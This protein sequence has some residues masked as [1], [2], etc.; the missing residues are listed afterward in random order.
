MRERELQLRRWARLLAP[1]L[2][3]LVGGLLALEEGHARG[4]SSAATSISI[5]IRPNPSNHG[6]P[7][8]IAGRLS[9]GGVA[10]QPVSIFNRPSGAA[11]FSQVARTATKSSGAYT[12]VVKGRAAATNGTWYVT[13]AGL[14][15]ATVNERVFSHVTL[16]S[17]TAGPAVAEKVT[18]SGR[19]SPAEPGG[20][21]QLQS[22]AGSRWMTIARPRLDRRSR[23]S[24]VKIFA[25]TGI[26]RLRALAPVSGGHGRWISPTIAIDVVAFGIHK[27]KH[28]VIIMQENRSFDHYFGTYP[29]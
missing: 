6:G 11:A 26:R 10:R 3:L 19:V 25:Q 28:V 22:Q 14:T 18:F 17:S 7:L 21:V 4:A 13:S 9:G 29:G 24:A 16:S 8:K 15:S 27:I 5:T 20:R 12:V 2:V 1:P 23:Y